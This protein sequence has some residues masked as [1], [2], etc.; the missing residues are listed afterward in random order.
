MK[1]GGNMDIH[2]IV[3][4]VGYLGSIL[5]VVSVLMTSM[6]KLR[7]VNSI[8]ASIFTVYALIIQSYPT[9]LMNFSLV[10]INLYYLARMKK[11]GKL[12]A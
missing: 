3:E 4:L 8:G 1:R 7:I 2:M 9:A 5:V 11:E 10:V 12:L 6:V